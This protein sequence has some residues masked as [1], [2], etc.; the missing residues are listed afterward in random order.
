M[1]A[2]LSTTAL[3]VLKTP[4]WLVPGRTV[5]VI[6][7][8]GDHAQHIFAA[9]EGPNLR[10]PLANPVLHQLHRL[11]PVCVLHCSV[12]GDSCVQPVGNRV[13]FALSSQLQRTPATRAPPISS[14]ETT[15]WM[16][17]SPSTYLW[18]GPCSCSMPPSC[19]PSGGPRWIWTGCVC[20]SRP[21]CTTPCS[22]VSPGW[23]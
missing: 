13:F 12:P 6:L 5:K 21:S 1:I 17:P 15:D 2:L 8:N 19:W 10:S 11:R 14:S 20:L 7:L 23:P 3:F 22:A 18:A 4:L 9:D 16:S